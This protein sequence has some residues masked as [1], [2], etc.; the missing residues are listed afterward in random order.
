MYLRDSCLL[1]VILM[2]Q[3]LLR[4]DPDL[5]YSKSVAGTNNEFLQHAKQQI[6]V[7]YHQS[8]ISGSGEMRL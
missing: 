2:H 6:R 8:L 7:L 5:L 3:D 1:T 4:P